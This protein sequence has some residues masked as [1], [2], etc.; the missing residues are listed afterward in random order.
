MNKVRGSAVYEETLD[1][2]LL[3]NPQR[4]SIHRIASVQEHD[5]ARSLHFFG[6]RTA[7]EWSGWYDHE[8]WTRLAGQAA[9][10]EPALRHALISLGALHESLETLQP[11]RK[12]KLWDLGLQQENKAL[13]CLNRDIHRMTLAAIL[14]C[15][16]MLSEYAAYVSDVTHL[17]LQLAQFEVVDHI[18]QLKDEGARCLSKSDFDYIQEH[19]QYLAE[20]QRSK[21]TSMID[22]IHSL[23]TTPA[24]KY[25]SGPSPGMP[26]TLTSLLQAR[27][28]LGSILNYA[29]HA[30]KI[31]PLFPGRD[32]LLDRWLSKLDEYQSSNIYTEES[33]HCYKLLRVTGKLCFMMIETMHA[34]NEMIFDLYEEDFR[35]FISTLETLQSFCNSRNRPLRRFGVDSGLL[36]LANLVAQN[37]CRDPTLRR[38]LIS[39]LND[40]EMEEGLEGGEAWAM[41]TEHVMLEEEKG[42]DPLPQCASDIPRENR[43]KLREIMY[44]F[45]AGMVHMT[46]LRYPYDPTD[47]D[48]V[49]HIWVS[50]P[51]TGD[52]LRAVEEDN[53]GQ[54]FAEPDIK[55][56][57]GFVEFL[58]C[59]K[60]YT[61]KS[62]RFVF[63]IPKVFG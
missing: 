37:W 1:L 61:I 4:P 59:R 54:T 56:G 11:D 12:A 57:V 23:R 45:K 53:V 47:A 9:M 22:P 40:T 20:K 19:L 51:T 63:P 62:K 32:L 2:A 35:D 44:H 58:W 16:V 43:L 25:W 41:T 24:E 34:D 17:R 27:D 18:H 52:D 29:T 38:R 28:V 26:K 6:E 30:T 55:V 49:Q 13:S 10:S 3:G 5:E 36:T 7:L 8:F 15:Y 46:A 48:L 39:L 14:I 31:D 50:F 42:L 60:D 21:W 33:L